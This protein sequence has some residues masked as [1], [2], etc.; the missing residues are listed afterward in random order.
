VA[1]RHGVWPTH[2]AD[3]LCVDCMVRRDPENAAPEDPSTG[4]RAAATTHERALLAIDTAERKA[5]LSLAGYKFWM[6]GYHAAQW[7]LLKGILP[8]HR[9]NPFKALVDQAKAVVAERGYKPGAE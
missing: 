8:G 5:W 1:R 2:E 6:F 4:P 7:V 3:C 9:P